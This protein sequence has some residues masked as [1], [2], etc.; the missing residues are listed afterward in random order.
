MKKKLTRKPTSVHDAILNF[1]HDEDFK[2]HSFSEPTICPPGSLEKI[3]IMR[4]R[5]EA[6]CVL[7]HPQD[8]TNDGFVGGRVEYNRNHYAKGVLKWVK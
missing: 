1:G 4:R 7:F 6:G 5:V 2:P 8:G 3:E